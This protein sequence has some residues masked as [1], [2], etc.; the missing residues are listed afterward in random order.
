MKKLYIYKSENAQINRYIQIMKQKAIPI[1][2]KRK[3]NK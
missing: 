1:L 3:E 2:N